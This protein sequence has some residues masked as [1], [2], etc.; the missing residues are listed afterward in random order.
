MTVQALA[1]G[2]E[3]ADE[4]SWKKAVEKA[5]KGAPLDKLNSRTRDGITVAPLYP[6]DADPRLVLRAGAGEPWRIA[7]RV[8]H[9]DP[10]EANAL[11][12]ADLQGGVSSLVLVGAGSPWSH[13]YGLTIDRL[14][15]LDRVLADVYL[16]LVEWRIDAG[17]E[18]RYLTAALLALAARRGIAAGQ[19]TVNCGF[20]PLGYLAA[21]GA[22]AVS[23]Q[24]AIARVVDTARYL[25]TTG[26]NGT[27]FT[28]DGRPWHAAGASEAQE[29]A[30]IAASL[31]EYWQ[32]LV[33]AGFDLAT[34][35]DRTEMLVVADQ[36]Q[37]ATIAK[38]RA[39]RLIHARMREA[40]GLSPAPAH[41]HAETA[42]RMMT[43]LDAHVNML[44]GTIA[45]FAAGVGGADSVTVLPFTQ[46]L[47]LPDA[48]AR[49]VARNGQSILIEESNLHRVGDP[50]AGS[51][52]VD[53]LTREIAEAAWARFQEIEAEGGLYA[54]LKAGKVQARVAATAAEEAKAVARRRAP[55]TGTSEFP[56][57]TETVPAVLDVAQPALSTLGGG[58]ALPEAGN[59]ELTAAIIAAFAAGEPIAAASAASWTTG[60]TIAPLAIGRAAAPFEALREA[61]GAYEAARGV[62]PQVFVA[63]LGRIADF[64]ARA[65]WVK[66]LFEAGGLA[67]R[68]GDGFAGSAAMVDAFEASGARVACIASSDAVYAGEAEKAARLLKNAGAEHVYLAGKPA[69]DAQ[70]AAFAAAGI[71]GYVHVGIDVVATLGEAQRLAGVTR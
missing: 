54:S 28:A 39:A 67:A 5:L 29:L 35:A 22:A 32:M 21:R 55:I 48:F 58:I 62:K 3:T 60:E 45:G 44:R 34:A 43:R 27:W 12:L 61:A 37:F 24:T 6:R 8:D 14:D 71:D 18:Y 46:A 4:T 20:D 66:N 65:T 10:A 51:G 2:F 52:Y 16:D 31:R 69:D 63:T 26:I 13:G 42:W 38:L 41:I 25:A 30:A 56:N 23:G 64:T 50:A 17:Y 40:A 49:R 9:P 57:I 68:V 7:A 1:T 33:D 11:A 59:G 15:D 47:G 70:A 53:T 36:N 19:L